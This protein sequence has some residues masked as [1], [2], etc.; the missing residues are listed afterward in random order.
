MGP[1]SMFRRGYE[2]CVGGGESTVNE[3][4]IC[5]AFQRRRQIFVSEPQALLYEN[6]LLTLPFLLRYLREKDYFA[7]CSS[8]GLADFL[9]FS[10]FFSAMTSRTSVPTAS[11]CFSPAAVRGEDVSGQG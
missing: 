11:K 5:A 4:V 10:L 3:C 6:I 7:P 8:V 1:V 9:V 2:G